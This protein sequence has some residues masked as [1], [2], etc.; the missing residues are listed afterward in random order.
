MSLYPKAFEFEES[1]KSA[2]KGFA[3]QH[4]IKPPN[5]QTFGFKTFLMAVKQKALEKIKLQTKV[6]LVL[7]AGMER[8][9]PTADVQSVIEVQ[10]F[11]SKT[12]CFGVNGFG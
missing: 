11:R 2:L 8:I 3:T 6:R 10:K 9:C 7:R 5:N 4:G 12:N 1:K